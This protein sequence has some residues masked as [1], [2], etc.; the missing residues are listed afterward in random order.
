[1]A[2]QQSHIDEALRRL[3]R[4]GRAAEGAVLLG[5]PA[6]ILVDEATRFD[7]DL[8]IVGSRGFGPI[9]SL[10][11]GSVSSEV[12]D[13]APCPVLVART[14]G[15]TRLLLAIDGSKPSAAAA[16][17]LASWRIFDRL[18]ICVLSVAHVVAPWYGEIAPM[19]P[20]VAKAY[21]LDLEHARAEHARIAEDAAAGLRA[22]GRAVETRSRTGDAAAEIIS[23]AEES[24]ADLVVIGSRGRTGVARL[25]LGSVARNV[26]HG[27]RASVLV[28]R[29]RERRS[30]GLPRG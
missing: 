18:P 11:L 23:A 1:M 29:T 2:V 16:E 27:S 4:D 17:V 15:I 9:A 20:Q 10:V 6:T 30:A 26:L 25:L 5:R 12:V 28:V 19:Y 22:A 13:Q 8:A 3:G 21:T 24:D 14:P 7:A